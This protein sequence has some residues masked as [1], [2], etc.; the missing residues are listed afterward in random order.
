MPGAVF[1]VFAAGP[2]DHFDGDFKFGDVNFV[3]DGAG[4]FLHLRGRAPL[5]FLKLALSIPP[6]LG[7]NHPVAAAGAVRTFDPAGVCDAFGFRQPNAFVDEFSADYK[8]QLR[9]K[10]AG[11]LENQR[12]PRSHPLVRQQSVMLIHLL[13]LGEVF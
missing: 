4:G 1:A 9:F 10:D 6:K 7:Y 12:P 11:A 13:A 3:H 8:L 2:R 5:G